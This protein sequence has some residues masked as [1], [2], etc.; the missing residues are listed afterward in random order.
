MIREVITPISSSNREMAPY[1]KRTGVVLPIWGDSGG[2]TNRHHAHY[3]RVLYEKGPQATRAFLRA[4]RFT[5]LQRVSKDDH[6]LYHD[7][8]DGTEFP[9]NERR[10]FLTIILNEAGYIPPWVVDVTSGTPTV[11]ETTAAMRELLRQPGIFTIER[12]PCRRAEIG[13][14]LMNYAT[15]QPLGHVKEGLLEEFVGLTPRCTRRSEE[16]RERKLYLGMKLTNTAIGVA[17]DPIERPFQ[18]ARDLQALKEAA[19]ISAFHEVKLYVSGHEPRYYETLRS[20][21]ATDIAA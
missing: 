11:T 6:Q 18:Q 2:E 9:A 20:Q 10:S 16:L 17:V 5:R 21:I 15:K 19:P 4:I 1:E 3:Y 14:F 7:N 12:S 13:Q 8:F